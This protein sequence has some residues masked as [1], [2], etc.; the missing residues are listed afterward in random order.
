MK[1]RLALAALVVA[2]GGV[3]VSAGAASAETSCY[4]AASCAPPASQVGG[5]GGSTQ[6]A[7]PAEPA[8]AA[9]QS[10]SGTTPL[11]LTGGDVAGLSV[12]GIGLLAGGTV[13]VRRGRARA[14]ETLY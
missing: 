14:S 2:A 8:V 10:P 3:A 1:V 6:P 4:P 11:P 7:Q 13:L 12:L 9:A 5:T